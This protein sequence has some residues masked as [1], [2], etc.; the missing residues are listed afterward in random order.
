MTQEKK[1]KFI[2]IRMGLR[3]HLVLFVCTTRLLNFWM[4]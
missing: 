4:I 1:F 3:T 2:D